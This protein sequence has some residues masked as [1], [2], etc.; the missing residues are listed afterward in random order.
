MTRFSAYTARYAIPGKNRGVTPPSPYDPLEDETCRRFVLPALE[1]VG[2]T[3]DQVKAAYPVTRGRIRAMAQLHRQDRPLIADYVLE[4][5]DGLPVAV[6]EAK[7]SRRDPADGFE[8]VKRYA[9][10][11]DVPFAYATNGRRILELDAR[12]GRLSEIDVFPSPDELWRRYKDDRDLTTQE[13][14][15]IAAA[16][17]KPKRNWD[18]TP[19]QPR[20]YQQIAINRAVQAIANGR[21]R[22][23]LVLATGTGKTLVAAQIVAKLWNSHWPDGRN[24]PRVL[25]LADRN[26][27]IDQPKD[28]YFQ[29][30]FGEA[31]H[32]LSASDFTTSRHIYLSLYQA[33]DGGPADENL[34]RKF[35]RDFFDLVIV[36]ECHRS[37]AVDGSQW[38]AILD[39]FEPAVQIGLTAAPITRKD[40]DT[41]QYFGEPLFEYSLAKGIDDGFLA[42][43]R[44]RRVRMNVDLTGWRPEPGQRDLRGVE[45]PERLYL[46]WEY[47]RLLA[48]LERTEEA[49]RYLTEYLRR[50]NRLGKTIVFCQDSD[51][52]F[53]MTQALHNANADLVRSHG[54]Q[55]VCRITA[56][57][58]DA[59][60][61]RLDEF[62]RP[63]TEVPTIAVTSRLLTTGVDIPTLRNIVLFRVIRSV[64]EFKQIIGRG[65]RL[66]P[67]AEK[68]SFDIIDFVEATRLFNDPGFDGPPLRLLR[69]VTDEDG[70]IVDTISDEI[71]DVDG[72]SVAEPSG[73][74]QEEPGGP[75]PP[76]V[77]DEAEQERLLASPRKFYVNGVEVVPAGSAFYIYD[78]DSGGLK[79]KEFSQFVRDQ[80]LSLR[81]EPYELLNQWAHV[82]TRRTL[83]RQLDDWHITAADLAEWMGRPDADTVD[84][85]LNVAW[86]VPLLSRAERARRVETRRRDFLASFPSVAEKVLA[87]MLD[88]FAAQGSEELDVAALRADIYRPLGTVVQ[89]AGH[90]GGGDELR[91][92]IDRL[93]ELLYASA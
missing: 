80:V 78:P 20:Y 88:Q 37:S 75:L 4:H 36:D 60:R 55:Y 51:H 73:E 21:E 85:L 49:A 42:P 93:G 15:R 62:R 58:G 5:S 25:Y 17:F 69:D 47:E 52:A 32:K 48:I 61:E 35:P 74:Y 33:L 90:F 7:R 2:W 71:P 30:M 63:E 41:Y 67:E 70:H 39:Y 28:D 79:L 46:P 68:F 24:R 81:L 43:Y 26:I 19:T 83:R 1:V 22:L 9:Q 82:Q 40:A 59:G 86:Q 8:Q 6:I 10:L 77:P 53:R 91:A 64:P 84:L 76:D 72:K 57:D 45:I 34:Y 14:D 23:L 11:L 27:L 56:A 3:P 66:F 12:A 38:R 29:P 65:T 89:I 87:T 44:V 50:T 16:A 54:Q 18:G 92:A 13:R 31:V